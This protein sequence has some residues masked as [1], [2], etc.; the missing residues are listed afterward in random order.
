GVW[1]MLAAAP[2]G[3]PKSAGEAIRVINSD[4]FNRLSE[5]RQRQYLAE[6]GDLIGDLSDEE[7]QDLFN[8]ES[9]RDALRQ[10]GQ[11]AFSEMARQ[12]ARGEQPQFPGFGG[13]GRPGGG[14]P[15]GNDDG[16]SNEP[17]EEER[18]NMRDRM[19]D[20][21]NDSISDRINSGN[22]QDFGLIG[23]FF[24]RRRSGN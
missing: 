8:D 11:N 6:A 18:D 16:D 21:I 24:Q 22:A 1:F 23:E 20:R 4:R 3:L 5:D 19:R 13:R 15:G 12:M 17:S 2:P 14:P 10:I 9:T 7:R